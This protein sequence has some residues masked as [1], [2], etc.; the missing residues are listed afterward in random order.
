MEWY[1]R[2]PGESYADRNYSNIGIYNS[3]IQNLYHPYVRPQE[4]GN[5][6]DVRWA[7]LTRKD[8]TGVL[9]GASETPLNI[10][11]LPYSP[12]QL[13]AGDDREAVQTHSELLEKDKNIHL[14]V[15]LIQA[16]VGGIDSWGSPAL[17]IYRVP[18]QNY[19]YSYWI[20]PLN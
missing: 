15:D 14:D 4:S 12:Q 20:I 10:I 2:G 19:A 11:A 6:T 5:H 1:G 8:G 9:I 3:S 18:Y 7:K 13:D 17:P 16:G